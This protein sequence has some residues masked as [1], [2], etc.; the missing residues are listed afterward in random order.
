VV[1]H[2]GQR[3][4]R[5]A[6]DPAVDGRIPDVVLRANPGTRLR[7]REVHQQSSRR[8]H[9]SRSSPLRRQLHRHC[10]GGAHAAGH[11]IRFV[12]ATG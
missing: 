12:Q 4:A 1:L 9:R 8:E 6:L 5:V 3:A 2:A 7:Q 10:A 11:R